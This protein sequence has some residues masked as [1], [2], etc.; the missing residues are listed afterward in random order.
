MDAIQ[1][2]G[3]LVVVKNGGTRRFRSKRERRAIVEETLKPGASV[4][5]PVPRVVYDGGSD[6]SS[7]GRVACS[8]MEA[9]GL[10]EGQ[11][12]R[13]AK[14]VGGRNRSG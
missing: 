2:T 13:P 3:K 12:S 1:Q 10:R 11:A 5:R 8:S 9:C 14:R 6:G 4:S 7:P